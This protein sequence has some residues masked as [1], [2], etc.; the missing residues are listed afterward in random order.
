MEKRS[1]LL[2][3]IFA[4][5]LTSCSVFDSTVRH[6]EETESSE[7]PVVETSVII[8]EMLET[9]RQHYVTALKKQ[10]LGFE[11]EALENYDLALKSLIKIS[12]YP[13]IEDNEA[14]H[15]LENAVFED[16]H[17]YVESLESLPE[18]ASVVAMEEWMLKNLQEIQLL[19]EEETDE[20]ASAVSDV[21]IIGDFPL[22]V[23]N[24]VEK[25]IEYFTGR[26]RHHVE[27]WLSRSGKYF[28]MMGK[29][30]AEEEVPQQ[31]IFL[32]MIE[33]G[34]NPSARSWA[35][36]MGMWQFMKGTGNLY[37]LDVE[38]YYD[39]R[40]DPEKATY[41]A[42]RHLRDLY[43]SLGDWYLAIAA[44]NSGEGRVRRAIRRSG[45][46]D[47]W[48]LRRY[49]PRETR[50][51]VPQYIA[52]TL[53]ASKPAEYGFTN[54]LYEKPLDFKTHVVNDAYDL[55]VLAKC[56][57]VDVDV[58]KDLNPELTQ[59]ST[60][61][62]YVGGYALKVPA[63]AYEAFAENIKNVPDE[64]KLQYVIHVVKR[65][66][67]LSGIA[68]KYGVG[69][70][71]LAD[72]NNMSLKRR[73]YPG[74]KLKIPVAR[75][76]DVD[77]A[78]NTDILPAIDD[79]P[80]H[81]EKAPYQ[82]S[83]TTSPDEEK[84]MKLYSQKEENT[85]EIVPEGK[86]K[87]AYNVKSRDKL[88]DIAELFDVRVSDLRN[89]N[90]LPYTT[91]IRVGQQLNVYVPKE[92]EEYYASIDGLSRT[93]RMGKLHASEGGSW[94]DHRIRR[95]EALSTIAMR[96]GVNVRQIKDW[97]DLYGSRIIAGKVLKIYTGKGEAPSTNSNSNS[98]ADRTLTRYRIKSGDTLSE[99]AMRF[100]VRTSD[101]RN[102]N[103]LRNNK[104]VTGKTLK[105]YTTENASAL[106]DNTAKAD[107]N[108][109][110]YTIKRGD[111]LSEIAEKFDVSTSELKSWNNISGN[112]IIAGKS[113]K[114]YSK[115]DAAEVL[116]SDNNE[117][118]TETATVS[119][120][121]SFKETKPGEPI[122][123]IV[124]KGETLGHI[125]ER[126]YIRAQDIRD[127]NNISGSRINVG[128]ELVIYPDE[129]EPDEKAAK[130]IEENYEGKVHVVKE[131]ESL[132]EIARNYDVTVQDLITWNKLDGDK[133]RKGKKL[134][135][136]Q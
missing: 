52:I 79:Q 13:G 118:T 57:G 15:E 38:F 64:A 95:G 97:N 117:E 96:Y 40:R 101:L 87:V 76:Q 62:K 27:R 7:L 23:N 108:L 63:Y 82:F 29:I 16:Y 92:K 2:L 8:N 3:V 122:H 130:N 90:G 127:W 100:G 47:F 19:E 83:V 59:N 109:I 126:Y 45:S 61:P 58:I 11:A 55:N 107:G 66:E 12:Y 120:S 129:P 43:Y 113:L 123:H 84:Y 24:Y 86:V 41:A 28:P 80:T 44:Y 36:A 21:I 94:I 133:I 60:P 73:I 32:S 131:G 31:L 121:D 20:E 69:T 81:D 125:A 30:F 111:A 18:G 10:K 74:N 6:T 78:I 4:V 88:V 67:T 132:W 51:Y 110:R 71:K 116:S 91:T 98:L 35:R 25:Y 103:G 9:A 65:G 114:I 34:L 115:V 39:E 22:E 54:I 17:A 93:E 77:F 70:Y 68:Y 26:G 104:I 50:N 136:L 5:F 112:K 1:L 46:T 53:I 89:W 37:D 105:V 135:I 128:Q 42:A 106:G 14:Y 124:K 102:W 33:S 99:I 56:A 72:F 75:F 85:E 48:S 49:L 134:K 119:N